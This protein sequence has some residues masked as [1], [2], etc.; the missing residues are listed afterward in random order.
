MKLHEAQLSII[1]PYLLQQ[2]EFSLLHVLSQ[3]NTIAYFVVDMT[4]I[5]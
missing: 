4:T 3:V 5:H 1:L 2:V